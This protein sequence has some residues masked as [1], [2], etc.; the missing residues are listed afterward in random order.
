M[1]RF[2]HD[3]AAMFRALREPIAGTATVSLHWSVG[4]AGAACL[5][6]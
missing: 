6:L 2:V 4:T 1:T 3:A 5:W